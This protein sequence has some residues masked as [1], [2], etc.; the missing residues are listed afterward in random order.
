MFVAW[1][2]IYHSEQNRQMKP[3]QQRKFWVIDT[4]TNGE[5]LKSK[6]ALGPFTSRKAAEKWLRDDAKDT[7]I[8]AGPDL[9]IDWSSDPMII[10]EEVCTV[11]QK[12]IV[13]VKVILTKA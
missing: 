6:T 8:S 11:I 13:N 7:Y 1:R 9:R 3:K 4:G 12:P 10:V 5:Y 2:R